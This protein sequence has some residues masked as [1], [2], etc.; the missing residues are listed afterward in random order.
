MEEAR[1]EPDRRCDAARVADLQTKFLEKLDVRRIARN[2]GGDGVVIV[3]TQLREEFRQRL[4]CI[5]H[6]VIL[7]LSKDVASRK[8]GHAEVGSVDVGRGLVELAVARVLPE[9]RD[10]II[11][12]F[13]YVG[14]IESVNSK[15]DSGCGHGDLPKIELLAEVVGIVHLQADR[16][17]ACRLERPQLIVDAGIGA[18]EIGADIYEDAVVGV[19]RRFAERLALD[20]HD[21]SPKFAGGFGDQLLGPR[22]EGFDL[23]MRDN[24]KL[25]AAVLREAANRCA[26]ANAGR[27]SG[28]DRSIVGVHCPERA[29]QQ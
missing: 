26:E 3:G 1:A 8:V 15:N 22:A 18:R 9:Q 11:F 28:V 13:L 25:V 2:V 27:A 14:L 21:A 12:R 20:R 5:L 19:V 16:G 10:G 29:I 23:R 6:L 4:R 7:S 17:M 24:G